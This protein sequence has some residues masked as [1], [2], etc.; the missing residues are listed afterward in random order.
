MRMLPFATNTR[1]SRRLRRARE[2]R[3]YRRFRV[4]A[5]AFAKAR[6]STWIR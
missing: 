6:A 1:G 4:V 5:S 3:Q 2:R